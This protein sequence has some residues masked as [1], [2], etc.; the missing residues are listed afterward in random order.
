[1]DSMTME[2]SSRN[3]GQTYEKKFCYAY[4]MH[5]VPALCVLRA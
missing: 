2:I 5:F 1:M 3:V 4:L